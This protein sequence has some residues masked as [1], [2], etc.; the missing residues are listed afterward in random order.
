V[1]KFTDSIFF[2]YGIEFMGQFLKPQQKTS[3]SDI[4]FPKMGICHFQYIG[5]GGDMNVSHQKLFIYQNKIKQFQT[6]QGLC[7]LQLQHWNDKIFMILWVWFTLLLFFSTVYYTQQ[8]IHFS[9][10]FFRVYSIWNGSFKWKVG[11][12]VI[13]K[14]TVRSQIFLHPSIQDINFPVCRLHVPLKNERKY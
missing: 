11:E 6:H 5:P 9:I 7:H 10:R 4:Y 2:Y 8:L 3:I 1:I 12:K 13:S 14:L